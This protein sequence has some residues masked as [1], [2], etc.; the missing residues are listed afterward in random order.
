MGNKTIRIQQFFLITFCIILL[1]FLILRSGENISQDYINNV[2]SSTYV[3]DDSTAKD[4]IQLTGTYKYIDDELVR[5]SDLS[6]YSKNYKIGSLYNHGTLFNGKKLT[7]LLDIYNYT[8]HDLVLHLGNITNIKNIY[9]NGSLLNVNS[10][11]AIKTNQSDAYIKIDNNANTNLVIQMERENFFIFG[12]LSPPELYTYDNLTSTYL[13][14]K[15]TTLVLSII[16]FILSIFLLT[17]SVLRSQKVDNNKHILFFT[18]IG[19]M[20]IIRTI[21]EYILIDNNYIY[22]SYPNYIKIQS[23]F[24]VLIPYLLFLFTF[25]SDKQEDSLYSFHTFINY[26]VASYFLFTIICPISGEEF[27]YKLGLFLIIVIQVCSLYIAK[28]NIC[29]YKSNSI[30][31]FV[32][33]TIFYIYAFTL[34]KNLLIYNNF[35]LSFSYILSICI[36][37][38]KIIISNA[39]SYEN[40]KYITKKQKVYNDMYLDELNIINRRLDIEKTAKEHALKIYKETKNRDTATGLFNRGYMSNKLLEIIKNLN[41]GE[42]ISLILLDIDNL[43]HINNLYGNNMADEI[44][45][46]ISRCLISNKMLNEYI[47]RWSGGTF[48][49]ALTHIDSSTAEYTAECIR[50]DI[51]A[52]KMPN[53]DNPTVS[54]GVCFANKN[55]TL[56]ETEV[57]LNVALEN[58]KKIGKNCVYTDQNLMGSNDKFFNSKIDNRT[59]NPYTSE[60]L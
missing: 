17:L 36:I 24:T 59:R 56:Q 30:L 22:I 51:T 18:L 55:S 6:S 27:L 57:L 9:I 42:V 35:N 8:D 25:Y 19:V 43:K 48:L 20:I 12:I 3:V 1:I 10:S 31:S 49:I 23:L 11:Q 58:A 32:V 60:L 5:P 13:D 26:T 50:K 40:F 4:Y 47:S 54:I 2:V 37:G 53:G 44:I 7:L 52:I 15:F 28:E 16:I 14:I 33:I 34:P 41:S 38:M 39:N 45:V 21:L 29:N 46:E